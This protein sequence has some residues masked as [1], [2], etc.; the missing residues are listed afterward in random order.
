MDIEQVD[1]REIRYFLAVAEEASFTRG[2]AAARVSQPAVS[3]AVKLLEERLGCDLFERIGRDVRLTP[4]GDEFRRHAL[5]LINLMGDVGVAMND[6]TQARRGSLTVG[7]VQTAN[8]CLLPRLLPKFL[9]AH[10]GIDLRIAE[11]SAGGIEDGLRRGE[12]HIGIG[13][14]VPPESALEFEPLLDEDLV[15]IGKSVGATMSPAKVAQRDLVLLGRG[16][17]TRNLI[18]TAFGGAGMP[19]RPV[20]EMNSIEGILAVV[21]DSAMLTILPK[22]A[23][24]TRSAR[25][26]K[27]ATVTPLPHRL[28]RVLGL[29]WRAG[30]YRS[31]LA[32]A[33]AEALRR[34]LLPGPSP[35]SSRR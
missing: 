21:S 8:A 23:L 14:A 27:S 13:F 22:L 30:A 24:E 11:H 7:V 18:D 10:P 4:A 2:A 6:F 19:L 28:R 31:P 5:R 29:L 25:G 16:F 35:A 26:L 3:Q 34:V 1:L 12:L 15:V 32:Q 20:L 9:K 33:F 17:C